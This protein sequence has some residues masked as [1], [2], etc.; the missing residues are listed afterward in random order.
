MADE[1]GSAADVCGVSVDAWG[2]DWLN[3]V[4]DDLRK[5][6]VPFVVRPSRRDL[7]YYASVWGRATERGPSN[8]W[9]AGSRIAC[10]R[11]WLL[12]QE[13]LREEAARGGVV[14]RVCVQLTIHH[15]RGHVWWLRHFYLRSWHHH[16]SVLRRPRR[17]SMVDVKAS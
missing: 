9:D 3:G 4:V 10:D 12:E 14:E 2:A 6:R 11:K 17:N 13:R 7:F 15:F 16:G 5:V 8:R 1:G